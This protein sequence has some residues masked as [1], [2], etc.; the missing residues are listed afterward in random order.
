MA[1]RAFDACVLE[2][3]S[4]ERGYTFWKEEV[5][6]PML[7]FPMAE[8]FWRRQTFD[9]TEMVKEQERHI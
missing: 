1:R 7:G 9:L 8:E 5:E 3:T 6:G 4:F 2:Q